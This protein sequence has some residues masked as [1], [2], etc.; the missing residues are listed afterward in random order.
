M[1]ETLIPNASGALITSV[2]NSTIRKN[3]VSDQFWKVFQIY[4]D[5]IFS[6]RYEGQNKG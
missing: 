5:R 1:L 4:L 3:R 2:D 6:V